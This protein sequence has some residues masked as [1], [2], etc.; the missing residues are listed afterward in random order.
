MSKPAIVAVP[1]LGGSSVVSILIAV[2]L[3][4]PFGPSSPNTSPLSTW[5]S[6]PSTAVSA[7]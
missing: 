6:S 4:A 3:P 7:P 5:I 2:V 1:A